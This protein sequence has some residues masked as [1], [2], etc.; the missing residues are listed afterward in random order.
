MPDPPKLSNIIGF[1]QDAGTATTR[2]VILT[3]V[4]V[5]EAV[6]VA[7]SQGRMQIT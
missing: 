3:G 7:P 2:A 6:I 5:R 4:D 1:C